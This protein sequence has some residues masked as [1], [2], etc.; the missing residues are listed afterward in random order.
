MGKE[1]HAD[2]LIDVVFLQRA[3]LAQLVYEEALEHTE[4]FEGDLGMYLAYLMGAILKNDR[5]ELFQDVATQVEVLGFFKTMFP[6][7]HPVWKYID[8]PEKS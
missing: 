6:A 8:T 2:L 7:E 1:L 4:T 3:R 5:I